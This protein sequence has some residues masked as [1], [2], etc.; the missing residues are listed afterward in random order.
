M[1][2]PGR[3]GRIGCVSVIAKWR[4]RLVDEQIGP[5]RAMLTR[6]AVLA[7]FGPDSGALRRWW[8]RHSAIRGRSDPAADSCAS[9]LDEF[10]K[11][12]KYLCRPKIH[13]V[14]RR[15]RHRP[16]MVVPRH[17]VSRGRGSRRAFRFGGYRDSRTPVSI[18]PRAGLR[19]EC[20]CPSF[21]NPLEAAT[22]VRAARHTH[23][24][25]H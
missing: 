23:L 14:T 13:I 22:Y 4:S 15:D 25:S 6:P 5:E 21:A 17:A 20:R 9:D 10:R 11:T 18:V 8:P 12:H 7:G 24:H 1:W 3:K 2:L 16:D 19:K